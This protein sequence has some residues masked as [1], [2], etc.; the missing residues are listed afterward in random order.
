[1]S[2]RNS[3]VCSTLL[4]TALACDN[5]PSASAPATAEAPKTLEAPKLAPT[6]SASA[7]PAESAAPERKPRRDRAGLA[8]AMYAAAAELDLPAD[9]KAALDKLYD[10]LGGGGPADPEA[11]KALNAAMTEGVK[12]GKVELAKLEPSLSEL[13]KAAAARKDAEVKAL[14]AL[15]KELDAAQ[16]KALVEGVKK[17]QAER[18]ARFK[19]RGKPEPDKAKD[20]ERAKRR[21]ERLSGELGLDADQQKR[22]EPILA[23]HDMGREG[24]KADGAREEMQKRMDALLTAFEKDTF[25]AAKLDFGADAKRHREMAKKQAEYLNAL[26]GVIKPEQRDKLAATLADRPRGPRGRGMRGPRPDRPMGGPPPAV[27]DP[28]D[29]LEDD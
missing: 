5:A 15:H 13:D 4:L 24:G 9:K 16:R 1:M 10:G 12:A 6:A 29:E 23:K 2:F 18:E 27:D 20:E 21:L 28:A 22:V 19:D 17:R 14:D 8:G 26:L 25:S 7:A 3:V 11:R